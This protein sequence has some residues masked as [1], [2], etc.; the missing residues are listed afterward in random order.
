MSI[1]KR[2]CETLMINYIFNF[3][4]KPGNNTLR[5]CTQGGKGR[6]MGL[7]F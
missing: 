3:L 2:L 5:L 1:A 4:L 7:K 6:G